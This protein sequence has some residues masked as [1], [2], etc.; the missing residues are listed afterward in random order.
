MV[1]HSLKKFLQW[2]WAKRK[3]KGERHLFS[4][5]NVGSETFA[6]SYV[7][8]ANKKDHKRLVYQY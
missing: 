3:H 1:P 6:V 7:R 8:G 5:L 2:K 4:K